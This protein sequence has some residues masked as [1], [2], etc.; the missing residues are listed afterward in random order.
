MIFVH[1]GERSY[2]TANSFES[3][4][5]T[6]FRV[7]FPGKI[8]GSIQILL[9][10]SRCHDNYV[11]KKSR[12]VVIMAENEKILDAAKAEIESVMNKAYENMSGSTGNAEQGEKGNGQPYV[13]P[14]QDPYG[15]AIKYL[16]KHNIMQ[17]FQ[18]FQT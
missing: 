13:E 4:T 11:N 7:F 12:A 17:L 8:T 5:F 14:I 10:P 1:S 9:Y 2:I 3:S 16:E 18:V 15:K 6:G